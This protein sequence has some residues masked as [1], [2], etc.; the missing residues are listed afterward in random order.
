MRILKALLS[1]SDKDGLDK[2]AKSLKGLEYSLYCTDGTANF[3]ESQGVEVH[4]LE[5]ITGFAQKANGRVKTLSDKVFEMILSDE[6]FDLVVVNLYPFSSAIS[7][8]T[9]AMIENFDIGGVAL[10]RAA[11]KNF[12]RVC[13]IS[14]KIQYDEFLKRY[15]LNLEDRKEF[16]RKAM[17][18]VVRYDTTI[19]KNLFDS[20]SS[21]AFEELSEL[22]YGENPHQRAWIGKVHGEPSFL[23]GIEVLKGSL[24]YNNYIDAFASVQIAHSCGKDGIAIVKHTNPCGV[25][26]FRENEVRT[27]ERAMSGD[28]KSAFGG[29]LCVNG[30]MDVEL[31]KSVKPYFLDLI[32]ATSFDEDAVEILK[33]KKASLVKYKF[34][35]SKKEWK[36]VDGTVLIQETNNCIPYEELKCVTSRNPKDSELKDVKFGLEIVKHVKSNA[37]ILV[38]NEKLIGLGAGQPSRVD[39]VKI[40]IEKAKEFG[41]DIKGAVMVSDGFFPFPD[42]AMLGIENGVTCVVEPGGSKRD[43]ETVKVCEENS[44]SLIFTH[45]RLFKH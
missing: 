14:E 40:A 26:A 21:I 9:D 22:R 10:L 25:S 43:K 19:L 35:S 1:V 6:G 2:F 39:S 4:R 15:P 36:I 5:E 38:K 42:S 17:E 20:L 44:V 23:D 29:V 16:A 41:H 33:K 7:R 18:S 45:K 3:L 12:K 27:F 8:G 34:V 30:K 28:P 31:A 24:S 32:L 37:V 11:S 13:V